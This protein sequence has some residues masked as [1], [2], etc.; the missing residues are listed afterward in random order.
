MKLMFGKGDKIESHYVAQAGLKLLGS[1]DPPI[2]ASQ[3]AG[4]TGLSYH[5]PA[6]ISTLKSFKRFSCLSL[7]SSWDYR[8]MPPR[9]A[10][11]CIFSRDA[12]SP[13]WPGWS[14]SPDLRRSLTHCNLCLLGSSD[15]PA[16]CHHTQLIFI[17]LVDM[18]FCQVGQ[19]GLELLTS[20]LLG[21]SFLYA[22]YDTSLKQ[23]SPYAHQLKAS[24]GE[25][26]TVEQPD[27]EKA[28][29]RDVGER[30]AD[31]R[32]RA[33]AAKPK[34]KN[35]GEQIIKRT[36]VEEGEMG[37]HHVGQ[38]GLKLL[39]SSDPPA[40]V[41]QS[42]KITGVSHHALPITPLSMSLWVNCLA[43]IYK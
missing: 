38:A 16:S 11:F 42:A 13:C 27:L 43:S 22:I 26:G 34:M 39:T 12:F 25:L 31:T 18:G 32:T 35:G 4:I 9:L 17:F 14:R 37:F 3:S 41:S 33:M 20:I 1:S 40:S 2:L 8:Y 7:L 29:Q 36:L 21:N 6:E 24:R 30:R 15:S 28:P 10:N 19:A 23:T 5:D